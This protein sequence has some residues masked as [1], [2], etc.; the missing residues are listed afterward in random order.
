MEI[1]LLMGQ[2][3]MSG[4]GDLAKL[5][6]AERRPDPAIR[7]YGNDGV[8][9]DALDPLDDASG[10]IDPVSADP[11]T[12]A[13]GPGLFFARALRRAAGGRIGLVPCAK[14]GSRIDAWM[15][16]PARDTLYGSCLARAREAATRGQIAGMLW[17][18]GESDTVTREQADRWPR[19]FATMIAA[20]RLDLAAPGLPLVI[21]G[22]ADRPPAEKPGARPYWAQVQS[23][24]ASLRM[25]CAQMVPAA[26]LPLKP[27]GLHLTTPA[28][29]Q[30]GVALS[31]AMIRLRKDVHCR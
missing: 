6:D 19:D 15:P 8:W 30:L 28:Q 17:Y 13:V 21:V 27:D 20:I 18:Q 3:N 25:S 29:R 2:S 4:R 24:Q 16:A 12:A 5:T 7:L 10:Q 11:A 14:G 9:R 23:A 31:Q 22:I 1:Y 26:G